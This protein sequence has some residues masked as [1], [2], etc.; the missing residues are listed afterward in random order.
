LHWAFAVFTY[1]TG[2]ELL[3]L[4]TDHT[5]LPHGWQPHNRLPESWGTI[6]GRRRFFLTQNQRPHLHLSICGRFSTG[7]FALM[8]HFRSAHTPHGR[9]SLM[10]NCMRCL[11]MIKIGNERMFWVVLSS[12]HSNTK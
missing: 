3:R 4:S 7:F 12:W 10:Y 2:L 5:A 1:R 9:Q 6:R 8:D 11:K